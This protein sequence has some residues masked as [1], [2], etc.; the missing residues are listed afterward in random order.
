[1]LFIYLPTYLPTYL[2][3]YAKVPDHVRQSETINSVYSNIF[4]TH[5]FY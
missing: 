3:H 1:M 4:Y 2:Y 5:T